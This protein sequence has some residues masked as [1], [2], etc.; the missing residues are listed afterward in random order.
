VIARVRKNL[1]LSWRWFTYWRKRYVWLRLA[2]VLLLFADPVRDVFRPTIRELVV[3][4][5]TGIETAGI[6][7]LTY[8]RARHLRQ[9]E[10]KKLQRSLLNR[11]DANRD[12]RLEKAEAQ[13]LA[14]G[15]GLAPKDITQSGLKADL[16]RLLAAN[17]KL[18]L[19][20]RELTSRKIRRGA[21]DAAQRETEVFY[22]EQHAEVERLLVVSRPTWR[23]YLQWKTWSRGGS[24][25]SGFL[26]Y[27]LE[28]ATTVN[29]P[30]WRWLVFVI[31]PAVL[32]SVWRFA[33]GEQLTRRFREEPELAAAPC[34]RCSEATRDLG[35]LRQRQLSRAVASGVAVMLAVYAILVVTVPARPSIGDI[36]DLHYHLPITPALPAGLAALLLRLILWPWEV[37]ACHRRPRL[38][39]IGLAASACLVVVAA[40]AVVWFTLKTLG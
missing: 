14:K 37:H 21:F 18:G 30:V 33:G 13:R 40:G 4:A 10:V 38:R 15:T 35:A 17:Q 12:R 34:P 28:E 8:Y 6:P 23:D 11:F 36:P 27:Y 31:L 3:I 25:F 5:I 7:R 39:L 9:L 16:D 32:V 22:R 2:I 24:Q 26:L 29:W 19:A 20:D 1:S